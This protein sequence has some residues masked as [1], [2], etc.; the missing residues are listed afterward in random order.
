MKVVVSI[1]LIDRMTRGSCLD[2]HGIH[3]TDTIQ[4]RSR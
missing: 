1:D 3:G 4:F 2:I